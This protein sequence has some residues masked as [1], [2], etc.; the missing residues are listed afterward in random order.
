MSRSAITFF[1][2]WAI[3]AAVLFG[4]W[5]RVR[6]KAVRARESV[7]WVTSDGQYL[8]G[9]MVDMVERLAPVMGWTFHGHVT[10]VLI[11]IGDGPM[12]FEKAR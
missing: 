3:P 4:D 2:L 9:A 6:R 5:W 1:S 10:F 7:L 12:I 11:D 8:S